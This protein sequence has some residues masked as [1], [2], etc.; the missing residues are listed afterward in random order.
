LLLYLSQQIASTGD[1]L[2][3]PIWS[4]SPLQ[5]NGYTLTSVAGCRECAVSAPQ[6][7][8]RE[9]GD[10]AQDILTAT[11]CVLADNAA[12][13]GSASLSLCNKGKRCQR[14]SSGGAQGN[15]PSARG[16]RVAGVMRRAKG[17]QNA[18]SSD[19]NPSF[20]E[21]NPDEPP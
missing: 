3:G 1:T 14:T 11:S 16:P 21:G 9:E 19:A 8:L 12:Y 20:P 18:G 10:A 6:D 5:S 17:K 2:L 7:N 13:M 15:L 4:V